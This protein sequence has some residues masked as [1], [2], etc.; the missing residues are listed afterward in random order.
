MNEKGIALILIFSTIAALAAIGAAIVL[1]SVA[2]S[3]YVQRYIES[4][5]AFW[6]AEAGVNRAKNGLRSNYYTTG[7]N[8]W[9]GPLG[10]GNYSVDV[11]DVTIDAKLCKN[12]TAYGYVPAVPPYRAQRTIQAIIKKQIPANFTDNAIYTSGDLD[13]S[14]DSYSVTGNVRYGGDYNVEHDHI[15]GTVTQDS[16]ISP[17]A[18]FDFTQLK[19]ISS[20]Q[21]NLYDITRLTRVE[22]GQE[23][24][25]STF[26]F[27]RGDDG[28]D[29]DGDGTIDE[30][31]EWVPN[32]LYCEGDLTL[33]GNIGTIGGFFVV[34]GDVITD[35]NDTEDMTINGNG[36]INGVIYTRGQFRIN[37]GGGNLNVMGGVWS[38]IKA[39]INGNANITYNQTYMNAIEGLNIEPDVQVTSW[40]EKTN[41]YKMYP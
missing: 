28:I 33:N 2:E 3:S 21:G 20:T 17:L 40:K 31:D 13:I 25:P 29:N 23:F 5:Q 10:N 39:R 4:T 22:H 16:G 14:G 15:T 12:V 27:T 35:P 41:P 19:N 34:V 9:H 26:W 24:F 36:Q 32:T 11:S 18:S 1:R 8:L 6:F 38:G 7:T 37:G 30:A